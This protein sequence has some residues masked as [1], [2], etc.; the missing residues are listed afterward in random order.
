MFFNYGV[1]IDSNGYTASAGADID[2]DNDYQSW[3]YKKQ[4]AG[5]DVD[6]KTLGKS[7]KCDEAYLANQ[8]VG[9]CA[10]NFGQSVF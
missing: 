8:V 5:S 1:A 9:P 2:A 3:G 10:A 4:N 6:A 7:G